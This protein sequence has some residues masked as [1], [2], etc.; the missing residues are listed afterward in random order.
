M[1]DDPTHDKDLGKRGAADKIKGKA[2]QA[3]GEVQK[4]AGQMTGNKEAEVKGQ[5]RKAEGK[6]Q[7]MGG[8]AE[9]K[10]DDRLDR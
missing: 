10:V 3:A 2:K 5:A 4:K 1:K 8:K 9:K 7:E 6:A